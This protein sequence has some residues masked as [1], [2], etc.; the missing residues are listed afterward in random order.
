MP[1]GER[2][3]HGQGARERLDVHELHLQTVRGSHREGEAEQCHLQADHFVNPALLIT[4]ISF[5]LHSVA[6]ILELVTT[7]IFVYNNYDG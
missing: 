5:I 7:D 1:C 4:D 6:V 3:G 2:G